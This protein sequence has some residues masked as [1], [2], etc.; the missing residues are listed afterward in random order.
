MSPDGE[1]TATRALT[2]DDG[3]AGARLDRVLA[4]A[5]PDLSRNR[6]A[7]LIRDGHLAVEGATVAEPSH[8]VKPGDRLH[9]AVPAA[10]GAIAPAPQ[11]AP[12][13]VVYED[14]HVIVVDKPAGMVVHPGAGTPGG[15]LVNALIARCGGGFVGSG[16]DQ[17]RGI[18]HRLDKDT[19]GLLIAAKTP[20]AE[21][22]LVAQFREH[23]VTRRYLG[24]AWGVPDPP[25]GTITG[26]I[27]RSPANRKKMTVRTEGGRPAT[28]HYGV[29]AVLAGAAVSLLDFRLETGRT[30]QIRVHM[31]HAGHALL[32]DPVY[33]RGTSSRRRLS[34]AARSA[35][36]ALGRQALHAAELGVVHPVTG[37]PIHV[38]RRTPADIAALVTALGGDL[39]NPDRINHI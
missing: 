16:P 3:D 15:T 18:V 21:A 26:A 24:V 35:L 12:L 33:G 10:T 5:W 36:D 31:A 19:S 2:V 1:P 39:A 22:G 4:R 7:R 8:K 30:H 9:L 17:R 25:Q 11:P 23:R 20:E 28:T 29:R 32:G 37:A 14:A 27:G 13:D 6:I 34:A 38:T